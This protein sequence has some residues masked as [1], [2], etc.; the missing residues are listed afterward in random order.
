MATIN[1]N[2]AMAWLKKMEERSN[3]NRQRFEARPSVPASQAWSGYQDKPGGQ[4]LMVRQMQRPEIDNTL[5]VKNDGTQTLVKKWKDPD[6]SNVKATALPPEPVMS[7]GRQLPPERA[8]PMWSAQPLN[9]LHWGRQNPNVPGSMGRDPGWSGVPR[10]RAAPAPR[11]VQPRVSDPMN[12]RPGTVGGSLH[13][14]ANIVN[15]GPPRVA[16]LRNRVREI[17]RQQ[18]AI[19][20]QQMPPPRFVPR[21]DPSQFPTVQDRN[22]GTYN[23]GDPGV[24]MG[25]GFDWSGQALRE[26]VGEDLRSIW[27]PIKE[28]MDK[29]LEDIR[30]R[31]EGQTMA[32]FDWRNN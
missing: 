11:R 8:N 21:V 25:G 3:I 18:F 4:R 5:T 19:P 29:I 30:K 26:N 12:T 14:P 10:A 32:P 6:Q 22:T 28:R 27:S 17:E 31:R 7:P 9:P 16:D 20:R 13:H 15:L 1:L 24:Q 23:L 2:D